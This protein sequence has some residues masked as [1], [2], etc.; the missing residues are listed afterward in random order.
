MAR[1]WADLGCSIL[2]RS[3]FGVDVVMYPCSQC[4]FRGGQ[5]TASSKAADNE[6]FGVWIDM[7][8][9]VE[10]RLDLDVVRVGARVQT[11]GV[12]G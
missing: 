4:S 7:S 9:R 5:C 3:T 10:A 6:Y 12:N 2:W 8:G 1:S 11:V